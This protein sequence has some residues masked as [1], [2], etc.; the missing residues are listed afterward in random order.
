MKIEFNKR[1]AS[2]ENDKEERP[3]IR[4]WDRWLYLLVLILAFGSLLKWWVTPK[5]FTS[6]DGVLMQQQYDIHFAEDIRLL[7]YLVGEDQEVQIGDTLFVFSNLRDDER[8]SFVGDSLQLRIQQQNA[9]RELIGIDAQ[10]EKRRLFLE[11]L[12]KR[13]QYWQAEKERKKKLTYLGVITP[14]ELANVDRSIDDVSHS[15]AVARSEYRVLARE[16]E[17]LL[18]GY[19]AIGTYAQEGLKL[20]F[21][22]RVF[23]SPVNGKV[24]RLRI[25]ENQIC[26]KEDIVT[27]ILYPNYFVRAYLNIQD[28]EHYKIGDAVEILLPYG[29][30]KL[31]GRIDKMYAVSELKE[32]VIKESRINTDKYGI[33]VEIYP[34]EGSKWEVLQVSNIPVKIRKNRIN[35]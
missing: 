29:K 24:D 16:K 5:I 1:V 19:N 26:Y 32:N 25:Q 31:K 14:N 23:V 4:R 18:E 3:Y 12:Q 22:K 2:I 13:L 8:N 10:I 34:Y 7:S 21:E 17:R 9:Y 35:F 30:K 11:D 20:R 6:A 33:V 27:S 15:I 28:L